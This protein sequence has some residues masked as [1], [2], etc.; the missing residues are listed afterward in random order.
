MLSS[1]RNIIHVHRRNHPARNILPHHLWLD[2]CIP[3]MWYIS[4]PK[5][6]GQMRTVSILK[7]S[8]TTPSDLIPM[9]TLFHKTEVDLGTDQLSWLPGSRTCRPS[10]IY[11]FIATLEWPLLFSAKESLKLEN[12]V[13]CDLLM[14]RTISRAMW[15][16]G[17]E[18]KDSRM[19]IPAMLLHRNIKWYDKNRV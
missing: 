19:S 6:R 11:C 12:V 1:R 14:L 16:V 7:S 18:N 2:Y 17:L 9:L 15:S 8:Q 4:S 13:E 3:E 10:L 5:V